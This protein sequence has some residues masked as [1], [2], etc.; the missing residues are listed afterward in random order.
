M[1]LAREKVTIPHLFQ[2]KARGEKITMLTC[3]D[4]PTALLQEKA[5]VDIILVGDS[6]AMTV[7]GHDSTLPATMDVMVVHTQAVRRGAPGAFLI[8]DMPYMS[9]QVSSQEAIRN[10]GRF[11]AEARCDAVK[12]EGGR[13]V[14]EVV[15]A[16][17]RATIPVMGHL[18][19][20]PQSIAQLGGFKAQ[21]R[22]AE[23]AWQ[24]VEDA[25]ALEQAGAFA[26]LVEAVP[27]EVGQLITE[28]ASIPIISIGAGLHC[29]GQLLIVHDMLGFFEAFTPK[30][31]KKY[32]DLNGI[33]LRAFREYIDE[34]VQGRFP[35]AEHCYSMKAGELARLQNLAREG[36]GA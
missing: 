7:L 16:L 31:V 19:L 13:N 29:D 15:A 20:T 17:T 5:G 4:Y 3:Y 2:K 6:L 8:G 22:D 9:Y 30:F 25:K 32:A 11:L 10:A 26:I 35:A 23:A 27:P 1:A 36:K 34:V 18:G 12:L 33:I 14:A 21:G 28:R 24:V